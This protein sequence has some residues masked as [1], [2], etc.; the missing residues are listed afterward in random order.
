MGG[1]ATSPNTR[2]SSTHVAPACRCSVANARWSSALCLATTAGSPGS[3]V[4]SEGDPA[5]FETTAAVLKG[6][7]VRDVRSATTF[8]ARSAAAA[9]VAPVAAIPAIVPF[10]RA[11]TLPTLSLSAAHRLAAAARSPPPFASTTSRGRYKGS[12]SGG[13]R[14]GDASSKYDSGTQ[15]RARSEPAPSPR[16]RRAAPSAFEAV[17]VNRRSAPSA[18]PSSSARNSAR[19]PG[20]GARNPKTRTAVG[21][22]VSSSSGNARGN[23]RGVRSRFSRFFLTPHNRR[24]SG[25][26]RSAATGTSVLR[27]ASAKHASRANASSAARAR[28]ASA[29]RPSANEPASEK[30]SARRRCRSRDASRSAAARDA[31]AAARRVASFRA[32]STEARSAAR[33]DCRTRRASPGA[34]DS[35][36]RLFA[37]AQRAATSARARSC[38]PRSRSSVHRRARSAVAVHGAHTSG[39]SGLCAAYRAGTGYGSEARSERKKRQCHVRS[40]I[41]GT[42]RK[43]RVRRGSRGARSATGG[44]DGGGQ[45]RRSRGFRARPRVRGRGGTGGTPRL[46]GA[47]RP[48]AGDRGSVPRETDTSATSFFPGKCLNDHEVGGARR[49][50]WQHGH[51]A[52]PRAL[53][54][55]LD[56][57]PLRDRSARARG[58]RRVR[59]APRRVEYEALSESA[60]ARLR[61]SR[62]RFHQSR[63]G[64]T[65]WVFFFFS[66]EKSTSRRLFSKAFDARLWRRASLRRPSRVLPTSPPGSPGR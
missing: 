59:P 7:G 55:A 5:V 33:R 45:R 62:A 53:A 9:A 41:S 50:T 6:V 60:R 21:T 54:A 40:A 24:V 17:S 22:P 32:A 66:D 31:F 38:A 35:F 2:S 46:V 56:M 34:R 42:P 47:R 27:S 51:V 25:S 65:L 61:K 43:A 48:V 63:T 4:E 1:A 23:A 18:A 49:Q 29:R 30:S 10:T 36:S 20:S 37:P 64:R 58:L 26:G 44:G 39:R 15:T 8:A 14:V 12:A 16:A 57:A 11:P 3:L 52:W 13:E 19:S 28:I